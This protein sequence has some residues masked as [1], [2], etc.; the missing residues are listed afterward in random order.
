MLIK[1]LLKLF[2]LREIEIRIY[3]T[4]FYQG[5][6]SAT[7][8][9]KQVS[10]SRTSVYDLLDKLVELGLILETIKNGVKMFLVVPPEK[11]Q[12][13]INEKQQ[14]IKFAQKTI[15]QM[16][17]VY[18]DQLKSDKP[19]IK[20]FEG[21]KELQQMMKDMLLYRDITI[22]AFWPIKKINRLLGKD[23]LR[24]FNKKRIERNIKIKVIWP[25][26]HVP[27]FKKYPFLKN[28]ENF[29]RQARIA[30]AQINFSLGYTIYGNT[31]RFLSSKKE[32][33]GFLVESN[34]LAEM[35]KNQF[36]VI[37]GISKKFK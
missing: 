26:S 12:L 37:W 24:E 30:P 25:S 18:D 13:L 19:N 10:I 35:M 23:F 5:I 15:K 33:F 31:V 14:K 11:L 22:Y 21:K 28:T 17:L 34:E 3:E 9:A 4:L 27:D 1:Q 16:Q 20:I 8:I 6:M 2:D 29:K 32:N 7:Q 36:E